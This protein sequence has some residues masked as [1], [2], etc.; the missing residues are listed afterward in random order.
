MNLLQ[1]THEAALEVA[2]TSD[3]QPFMDVLKMGATIN[4]YSAL[5]EAQEIAPGEALEIGCSW[6]PVRPIVGPMPRPVVSFEPEIIS[7][8][9]SAVEILRPRSP[10]EGERIFGFVELLEQPAQEVLIGDL[11]IKALVGK[12]RKVHLSLQQPDYGEAILAFKEKRPI[13][14]VGDLLKTGNQWLLQN[15]RKM[16]VHPGQDAIVEEDETAIKN[17]L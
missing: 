10:K 3:F 12:P 17:G 13:E 6:A 2:Q 11:A 16:V 1:Y 9:R 5:V 15:P 14:V 7:P 4:L 8:I